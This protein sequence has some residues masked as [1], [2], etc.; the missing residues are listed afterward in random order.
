MNLI[1]VIIRLY[2]YFQTFFQKRLCKKVFC[3]TV[4]LSPQLQLKQK[5]KRWSINSILESCSYIMM[6]VNGEKSIVRE[7]IYMHLK[8][9]E[10]VP[11]C[12]LFFQTMQYKCF[13][14][15]QVKVIHT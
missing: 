1:T 13:I 4:L 12:V 15:V 2:N 5:Q 14:R 11:G 7:F 10:E 6:S 8:Q 9:K 3:A